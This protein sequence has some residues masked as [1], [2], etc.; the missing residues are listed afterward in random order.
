M[1]AAQ[2]RLVVAG[3]L[4]L[5]GALLGGLMAITAGIQ[6]SLGFT[7]LGAA[8]AAIAGASLA[9]SIVARR[10]A[11][12]VATAI[13]TYVVGVLLFPPF[14]ILAG[15]GAPGLAGSLRADENLLA[16]YFFGPVGLLVAL[17]FLPA[18]IACGILGARLVQ[19]R[20]PRDDPPDV[21]GDAAAN[22][23]FRRRVLWAGIGLVSVASLGFVLLSS[24]AAGGP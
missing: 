22:R 7:A 4:A 23:R 2:D 15:V 20:I 19:A 11:V 8:S 12:G 10:P 24:M 17:P 21:E 13:V 3:I 18:V 5:V 16:I 14:S 1:N 9:P 6:G